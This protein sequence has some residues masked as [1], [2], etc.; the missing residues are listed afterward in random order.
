LALPGPPL[1]EAV[2]H[3][4]C[5][6]AIGSHFTNASDAVCDQERHI[7]F[8]RSTALEQMRMHVPKTRNQE[9][10]RSG[11][12]QRVLRNSDFSG[13]TDT[14][15]ADALHYNRDADLGPP[16]PYIDKSHTGEGN[17][18]RGRKRDLGRQGRL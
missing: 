4:R 5:R 9:F 2:S 13:L 15:Y 17:W 11:N 8:S 10:S 16:V 6:H 1:R 3:R 12:H 14:R 7:N 18:T